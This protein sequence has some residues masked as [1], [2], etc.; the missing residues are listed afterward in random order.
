[1]CLALWRTSYLFVLEPLHT[2]G[3]ADT[4]CSSNIFSRKS[5]PTSHHKCSSHKTQNTNRCKCTSNSFLLFP[6][7]SRY[8]A[9]PL[10]CCGLPFPPSFVLLLFLQ[11]GL[12]ESFTSRQ[13]LRSAFMFD[14]LSLPLPES[15]DL[16]LALFD[17][18]KSCWG[19][20]L[21]TLSVCHSTALPPS[22]DGP[23]KRH[24]R[25]VSKNSSC[26]LLR[27]L[28]NCVP[29]ARVCSF[30]GIMRRTVFS[31]NRYIANTSLFSQQTRCQK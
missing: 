23:Q 26:P 21:R 29:I 22:L 8:I 20:F 13:I 19:L 16:L 7:S 10:A 5:A 4:C 2:N 9:L 31:E 14:L 12:L 30:P 1:M 17:G 11:W 25:H 18:G 3:R 15:V 28:R 6:G 27:P 24:C